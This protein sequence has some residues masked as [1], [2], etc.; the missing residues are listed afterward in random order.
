MTERLRQLLD[1]AVDGLEPRDVDPLG[2]ILR[3]ERTGRRR[4]VAAGLAVAVLAVGAITAGE[5]MINSPATK[6]AEPLRVAGRIADTPPVPRIVDGTMIAGAVEMRIPEGWQALD[7]TQKTRCAPAPEKDTVVIVHTAAG[8]CRIG[9]EVSGSGDRTVDRIVRRKQ[10]SAGDVRVIGQP[11][12]VITLPG[13]EP[14]WLG[15]TFRVRDPQTN[16]LQ[17]RTVMVLPWSLVTY[18]SFVDYSTNRQLLRPSRT[19][20]IEA[21]VLTLPATAARAYYSGPDAHGELTDSASIVRLLQAMRAETDVVENAEACANASQQTAQITFLPTDAPLT[22][23]YEPSDPT[24]FRV[25]I[26]FGACQEAVSSHGGRVRLT[27]AAVT[28]LKTIFGI[29]AR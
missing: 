6:R 2:S 19:A 9:V 10:D 18:E 13:G 28:E 21:G 20:P 16:R 11:P 3:R 25:V 23:T 15:E 22:Q 5:L 8:P 4:T 1:D 27:D 14:A 12:A 29:G 7:D 26:A 17:Y 24:V